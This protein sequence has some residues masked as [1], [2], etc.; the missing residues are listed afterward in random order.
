[1]G[2]CDQTRPEKFFSTIVYNSMKLVITF[3]KLVNHWRYVYAGICSPNDIL[4][5][6]NYESGDY[7]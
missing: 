5:I 2:F 1:M 6:E 4:E 3:Q 7:N